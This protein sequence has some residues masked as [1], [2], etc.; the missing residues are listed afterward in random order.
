LAVL[1][2]ESAPM[3]DSKVSGWPAP[4]TQDEIGTAGIGDSGNSLKPGM[5]E[6]KLFNV[7][8]ESKRV[9][10]KSLKGWLYEL[11]Y[12]IAIHLDIKS[13]HV[14]GSWPILCTLEDLAE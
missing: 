1:D 4:G 8:K 11:A 5:W 13:A 14:V 2:K 10:F 7:C 3:L 6:M 12:H 9:G